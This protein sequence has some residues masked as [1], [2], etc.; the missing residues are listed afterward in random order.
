MYVD[1]IP[2]YPNLFE[3]LTISRWNLQHQEQKKIKNCIF[4]VGDRC[5]YL[6]LNSG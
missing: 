6:I 5:K 1:V 2:S 3:I 4:N